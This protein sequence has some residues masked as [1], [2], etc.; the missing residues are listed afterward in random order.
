MAE[1]VVDL[2]EYRARKDQATSDQEILRV[3][4]EVGL[5]ALA[6][7]RQFSERYPHL[8]DT[9][10]AFLVNQQLLSTACSGAETGHEGSKRMLSHAMHLLEVYENY[11]NHRGQSFRV[12]HPSHHANSSSAPGSQ[13]H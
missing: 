2:V 5:A 7:V 13:I 1:K 9:F 8:P 11:L 10:F 12:A 4:E 6:L 3:S